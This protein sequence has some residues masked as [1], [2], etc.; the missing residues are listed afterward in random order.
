[1]QAVLGGERPR[2]PDTSQERGMLPEEHTNT[3]FLSFASFR[4]CYHV[5]V[6]LVDYWLLYGIRYTGT[7]SNKCISR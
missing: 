2:I 3:G 6:L 4:L 5:L 7:H 1:M